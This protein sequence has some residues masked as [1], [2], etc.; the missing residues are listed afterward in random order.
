MNK[1]YLNYL[2]KT[3]K[4]LIIFFFAA[5]LCVS[6]TWNLAGVN[7]VP[8][9]G[10]YS[11]VKAAIA[12]SVVLC[13]ALPVLLFSFV[14]QRSSVD[15]FFALP[16]SRK[17]QR[18]T[19][20]LFAFG[21][22][23]GY[24]LI[25]TVLAWLLFGLR[26]VTILRLLGILLF[27]AFLVITLLVFNSVLYL[28][29]N[30]MIDGVVTLAAYTMFPLFGTIA[31]ALIVSNIVA[32]GTPQVREAIFDFLSPVMLLVRNF[33]AMVSINGWLY[34]PF[35]V[36][37]LILSIAWLILGWFGLR[38]QFDERK[39]ERAGQISDHPLTYPAIINLYAV[40]FL[41]VFASFLVSSPSA[42]LIVMYVFLLVCY[43]AATFLYRR[44]LKVD[45]KTVGIYLL[46]AVLCAALMFA[47]WKTQGFGSAKNYPLKEEPYALYEYN[48]Q[49][50]L[51]NLGT[52]SLTADSAY[53]Q[54][55][56]PVSTDG[57]N[58]DKEL[59]DLLEAY[60]HRAI[61]EF[62]EN[63]SPAETASFRVYIAKDARTHYE[64]SFYYNPSV[65]F[66]EEE[67]KTISKYGDVNIYTYGENWPEEEYKLDEFLK[68]RDALE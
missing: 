38:K 25:T 61:D 33:S 24:F 16:V 44:K 41:L 28:L 31:E 32:G 12:I 27:A 43:V 9:Y 29:G 15:L 54:F 53:V 14:H 6:L 10:F 3:R 40:L 23:F 37:Y 18:L 58:N 51:N 11:A 36:P 42:E 1:N 39:S 55:S 63:R 26:T 13:Y 64:N 56:I 5:Y 60:R 20:L 66:T 46:E 17:E 22:A 4:A 59:L 68:K 57:S 45:A 65:P 52:I 47:G 62:Y 8:G 67:M 34:M 2:I 50:D 7:T 35:N 49:T 19:I 21:I 48:V 30:N